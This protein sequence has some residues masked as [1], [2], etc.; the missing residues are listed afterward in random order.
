MTYAGPPP[1]RSSDVVWA[2]GRRPVVGVLDTGCGSH[3]WLN[4]V[5]RDDVT[6]DGT[7]IGYG[8]ALVP[9]HPERGGDFVGPLD[10]V[11]DTL[12][13]HG[14]FICGLVHQSCPD[15]DILAWR[16]VPSEGLIVEGDWLKALAEIAELAR[17]HAM[18]EGGHPLDVLNLSMGYYHETPDDELLFDPLVVPILKTLATSGTAVVCSAGNDATARP[19]FPA[20]FAPWTDGKG[21]SQGSADLSVVS[22]G[23][24]NPN[25]TTV[26]LFSNTGPWVNTYAAGAAVMSTMPPL[27]GGLQPSARTTAFGLIRESIDP[28][29]FSH[30]GQAEGGY[31]L[32]SGTSF[33]A[34]T[35]AGRIAAA[36]GVEI[37]D[38]DAKVTAQRMRAAIAKV[39]TAS[40]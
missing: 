34:P 18:G 2:N 25:L 22:V 5:V 31:A 32:W 28:D 10:G 30:G 33:A 27:Q 39:L 29:Q 19:L 4:G 38:G 3:P 40:S 6:L 12:S 16:V 17:R 15:A 35:V 14:T 21:P 26:A 36:L 7:V 1:V 8:N 23:A 37:N 13:A 20:A 11:L 9:P 24:L